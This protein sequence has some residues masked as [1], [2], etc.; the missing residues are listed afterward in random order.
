MDREKIR[1]VLEKWGYVRFGMV[2]AKPAIMLL[3]PRYELNDLDD[4]IKEL[5]CLGLKV[6]TV[7]IEFWSD[8]IVEITMALK[9]G[10]EDDTGSKCD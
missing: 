5:E 3:A 2:L 4:I 10:E 8:N 9:E 1:E 7:D 6:D